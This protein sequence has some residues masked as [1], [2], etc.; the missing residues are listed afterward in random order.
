MPFWLNGGV[1][2]L[3]SRFAAVNLLIQSKSVIK[4]GW[5]GVAFNHRGL[6]LW[7]TRQGHGPKSQRE[8]V[9]VAT[10]FPCWNTQMPESLCSVSQTSSWWGLAKDR[11]SS[12]SF[13]RREHTVARSWILGDMSSNFGKLMCAILRLLRLLC[14]CV[15]CVF[16]VCCVNALMRLLR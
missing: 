6:L 9:A 4:G 1:A 2:S 13:L 16:C 11:I 8:A 14:F 12:R 5:F 3:S 15:F 7:W 10:A